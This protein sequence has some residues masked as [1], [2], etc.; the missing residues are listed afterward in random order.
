MYTHSCFCFLLFSYTQLRL[1]CRVANVTPCSNFVFSCY[2][3]YGLYTEYK[4]G[5][6]SEL[7]ILSEYVNK[8]GKLGEM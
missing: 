1:S 3:V 8:T 6:N 2:S 5:Q 4:E 7:L